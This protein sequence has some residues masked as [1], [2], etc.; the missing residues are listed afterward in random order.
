[1][2][3]H[4]FFPP[5]TATGIPL[6]IRTPPKT[7]KAGSSATWKGRYPDVSFH[8][9]VIFAVVPFAMVEFSVVFELAKDV[10]F[11]VNVKTKVDVVVVDPD[12]WGIKDVI[13]VVRSD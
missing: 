1:M 4:R 12:D 3:Y 7:P 9:I 13:V 11:R 5:S 2:T 10:E 8:G 6:T